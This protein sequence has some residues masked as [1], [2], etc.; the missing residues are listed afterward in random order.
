MPLIPLTPATCVCVPGRCPPD[1][2]PPAPSPVQRAAA[3]LP[4]AALHSGGLSAATSGEPSLSSHGG[5][6][7]S[8]EP[9]VRVHPIGVPAVVML[10]IHIFASI[11][12]RVGYWRSNRALWKFPA[13]ASELS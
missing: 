2:L 4:A 7:A 1:L 5:C 6:Q 12:V 9:P 11:S 10:H 8:L 13:S 3:F